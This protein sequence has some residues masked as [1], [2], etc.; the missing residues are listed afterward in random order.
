[1]R[2]MRWESE[3]C[4]LVQRRQILGFRNRRQTVAPIPPQLAFY[5]ALLVPFRRVA[6][7][8]LISPVRSERNDPVGFDALPPTQ[9]LLHQRPHVV[10]TQG[11]KQA[12]E[13]GERQLVRFQ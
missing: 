13:I 11:A 2:A 10:V 12:A 6:E 3:N 4:M 1:M 8:A 9:D 7:L 5:S